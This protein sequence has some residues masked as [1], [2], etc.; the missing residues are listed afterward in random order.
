MRYGFPADRHYIRFGEIHTMKGI[1]LESPASGYLVDDIIRFRQRLKYLERYI[2]TRS[3]E[4]KNEYNQAL[5][6]ILDA[7]KALSHFAQVFNNS[8]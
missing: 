7:E 3:Q 4:V 8:K 5:T 2:Q 1:F 6:K